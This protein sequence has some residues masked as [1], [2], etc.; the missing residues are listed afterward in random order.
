MF[1]LCMKVYFQTPAES[2]VAR[3]VSGVAGTLSSPGVAGYYQNGLNT[4]TRIKA[5]LGSR[6]EVIDDYFSISKVKQN[7]YHTNPRK[8]KLLKL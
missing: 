4:I 8:E 7:I 5:P 1:T 6:S 3:V 2:T